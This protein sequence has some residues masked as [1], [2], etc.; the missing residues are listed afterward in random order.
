MIYPITQLFYQSVAKVKFAVLAH[1]PLPRPDIGRFTLRA[2]TPDPFLI[3]VNKQSRDSRRIGEIIPQKTRVPTVNLCAIDTAPV[4]QIDRRTYD[5]EIAKPVGVPATRGKFVLRVPNEL[6]TSKR[7][8][9]SFKRAPEHG[10][11]TVTRR[12]G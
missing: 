4:E 11:T 8:L 12:F 2:Q 9:F 1:N 6:K 10:L 3:V 5:E 7:R